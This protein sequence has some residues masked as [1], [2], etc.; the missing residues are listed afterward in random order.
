M[1]PKKIGRYEIK[2]EIGRGCMSTVYR[3][4]DPSFNR[5][6]A[7]KVLP[8]EMLH[9]LQFRV[10]FQRE[11]KMIASLEHP[12][13]VPVYDVGE[14]EG[15]PYFVMRYM[16]GGSLADWIKKGKF[17]LQDTAR[18][19]ERLASGLEYAHNKG[20]VHRDLKPEN[21]LF[22]RN[23]NPYITDFSVAKLLADAVISTTG[24]GIIGTPAYIS[25][26]QAQSGEVD[27]RSDIYGLG[28]IIY[29]MLTGKQPYHTEDPMG[30][31]V[32]HVSEPVP[33]IL[34]ID[35]NLP[36]AVDTII[37]TAMAKNKEE[38]YAGM[39]DLARA[40]NLAA[41][42]ADKEIPTA[43][44]MLDRRTPSILSR[45]RPGIV[46]AGFIVLFA[47]FGAFLF[48]G[49]LPVFLMQ[50]TSTPVPSLTSTLSVVK[51]SFTFTPAQ[52]TIT[53]TREPTQESP[54]ITPMPGGTD[55]VAFLSSNVV[56]IMNVDGTELQ[57]VTRPGS[58]KFGLQWLPDGK[59]LIYISGKCLF[60]VDIQ[61]VQAQA[62]TCF[63]AAEFFEGF[64]ISP[65]GARVAISVNRELF[66]VPFDLEVLT[67]ADSKADLLAIKDRCFYNGLSIRNLRWS[68]DG[69]RIA[70]LVL[71]FN[72]SQVTDQIYLLDISNCPIVEPVKLDKF[73]A[74]HFSI[75]SSSIPSFDWDGNQ[76]FLINDYSRNEG[77]GNLYLYDSQ[78]QQGKRINPVNGV[79][80]YRDARWSPD[81][82]YIL[83]LYQDRQKSEIQLYFVRYSNLGNGQSFVPVQIPGLLFSN[84]R[85]KPQPELRLAQ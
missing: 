9:N 26:E 27:N 78:K 80:C 47:I 84:S 5:E 23:D 11:L 51:P 21:V 7:I 15:Q 77:F 81:G 46:I 40:L 44:I 30:V 6:V 61:S 31:L 2:A 58:A 17:S 35:P 10:R 79:C 36:E 60:R 45:K 63:N 73:P 19:I 32:K 39:I 42:G 38:R 8:R 57:P 16:A 20:I 24:H 14:H 53:P 69:K 55:K 56:Y 62:I 22:D 50:A 67:K 1:P 33:E 66:I 41:F 29:E 25:P 71:D 82:R 85:E 74:G 13:I 65:D 4:H 68:K 70:A 49:Q 3:A 28:V 59:G 72:G 75:S 83:F 43:P 48:R 76:L 64:R 37:K 18:I 34:Q 52:L 12:A 54:T